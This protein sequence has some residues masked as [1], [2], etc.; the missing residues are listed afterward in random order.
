MKILNIEVLRC[1]TSAKA[2]ITATSMSL[3]KI[4]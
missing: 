3:K 2:F 1:K 4:A